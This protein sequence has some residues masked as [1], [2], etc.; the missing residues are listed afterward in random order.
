MNI[1]DLQGLNLDAET[2]GCVTCFSIWSSSDR[3]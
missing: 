3:G 1:L 2:L